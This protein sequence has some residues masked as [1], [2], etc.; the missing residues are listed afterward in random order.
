MG[1][2]S[3]GEWL[4][5]AEAARL[6]PLDAQILIAHALGRDRSWV[7]AHPDAACAEAVQGLLERRAKGEP[8]AYILGWREFYGRRFR[9]DRRV[10]IPR[11]ET[12]TLVDVALEL[13]PRNARA[14]DF[15]TGSG[16][17]GITL[18]LHRPDWQVSLF[19]VSLDALEVART[20]ARDL[21]ARVAM[22]GSGD[23]PAGPFD[24]V[25]ANPPYVAE[26]AELPTEVADYEPSIALYAGKDGLEVLRQLIAYGWD[27]LVPGGVLA[28]E[29]GFDQGWTVPTLFAEAGWRIL[30]VRPDLAGIP[31]VVVAQKP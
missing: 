10:L 18:A 5:W 14:L 28:T 15:G 31:R 19:D 4:R 23:R 24:L 7:L 17:V 26:G 16:C 6:A 27:V 12:E 13:G 25:V 8:L 21:S 11:Q 3:V 1:P 30:G 29:V 20:N 2:S 22:P 9:V